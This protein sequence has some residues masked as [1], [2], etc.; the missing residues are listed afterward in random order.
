MSQPIQTPPQAIVRQLCMG[1]RASQVAY[2]AAQLGLAD[3]L[4]DRAM[5]S[6]QLASVTSTDHTALRR[7]L[8]ALVAL[9]VLAE[10]EPDRFS[11]TPAG[12]LLRSD[13]GQSLR[14]LVLF[15]T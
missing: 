2:I 9:G 4:A 15:L 7:V 11:L 3:A 12:Q 5:T 13:H 8:R 1:L 10:R 6:Q 14:A